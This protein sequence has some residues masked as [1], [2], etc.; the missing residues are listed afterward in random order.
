MARV[1]GM[2]TRSSNYEVSVKKPL[3]ARSLVKTYED[4]LLESN[5]LNS[6]GKSIAY[7]GMLVAVANTDDTSKN[8]LYFLFDINCTTT[9][10]SPNV[11]NEANWLRIGD[12][13]EISDLVDRIVKID[14]E[15]SDIN[16]RL[17]AL[18]ADN[19]HPYGYRKDFPE[20]GQQ[21]HMYIAAD[22]H[23]T[24]VFVGGR[25]LPIADQFDYTDHDNN[26]ETPEVRIIYGGSA[27]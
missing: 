21:N 17:D 10:K 19:T 6:S 1:K 14:T 26:S 18:E 2:I 12:T 11:T 16:D 8:G 5:W 9:L 22:E 24:Y 20:V 3:D 13:S 4:L 27:D 23:R 25:Y 7:N 15:L